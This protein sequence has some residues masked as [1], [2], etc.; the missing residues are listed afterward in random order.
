MLLTI[1][2]LFAVQMALAWGII[3]LVGRFVSQRIAIGMAML[4][5]AY[6]VYLSVQTWV[7]CAT[8][9]ASIPAASGETGDDT[10]VFACDSAGG[11]MDYFFANFLAPAAVLILGVLTYRRWRALHER[12]PQ[13]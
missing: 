10:I 13:Q 12:R 6:L 1:T 2:L 5:M 3:A 8:G 7:Y 4:L 9:P 11:A